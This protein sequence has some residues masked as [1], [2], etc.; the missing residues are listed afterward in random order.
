VAPETA[1]Q[2]RLANNQHHGTG[3]NPVVMQSIHDCLTRENNFINIY[4]SAFEIFQNLERNNP[5][6]LS[7]AHVKL[8]FSNKND[9]RTYNMPTA[10]EVA[11]ILPGPG[12]KTDYRDI[13][14]HYRAGPGSLKRISEMNPAYT[15]LH[16]VL[17]FPR[18]ELGWH[19]H[20]QFANPLAHQV[21][22]DDPDPE[23]QS[24]SKTVTLM[25]YYAYRLHQRTQLESDHLFHAKHLFQQYIVDAFAQM[26]Q[27][28]LNWFRFNQ[29]T[30]RSEVYHGL[31]DAFTQNDVNPANA[32]AN[33]NVNGVDPQNIGQPV[34]LPSS[35]IG[36]SR[37]MFQLYQDSIALARTFGKPD[38]FL[39]ITANPNWPEIKD[40]LL[41]GQTAQDRPD[42]VARVFREKIHM[43]LSGIFNKKGFF[44]K[45]RGIIYTIEFQKRG[46]PHVH[47]LIFLDPEARYL[48]PPQI[49]TIVSA[50]LPNPGTPLFDLVSKFMVHGPCGHHNP[51]A[52]CIVNNR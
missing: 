10:D 1:L 50:Q 12:S 26:D 13:I 40:A 11:A 44:G 9:S 45:C 27:D 29:N 48:L 34:I 2:K 3:L 15:P 21:E 49:D 31:V 42:L 51:K 17:L 20:I 46:L 23:D 36:G 41:P 8:H 32:N 14:L 43:I 16:Y 24:N 38:L 18:G 6:S 52:P 33:A 4:K 47:I 5:E 35:Y 25:Q 30:I 7:T 39:T 22:P 37:H 19:K 28:R